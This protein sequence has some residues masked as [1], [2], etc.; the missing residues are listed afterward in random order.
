[1]KKL[2]VL[3]TDSGTGAFYQI[4]TGWMNALKYAGHNASIWDG[5]ITTWNN[6]KPDI[7]IGC[8]GWRQNFRKLAD[9][10]KTK[11]VI[12]A[13]PYCSQTIQHGGPKINESD[14]AIG[15][16]IKQRPN[17]AFGYGLQDDIDNY[18][19][20]WNSH[21]INVMPMPNAADVIKY[22]PV[23]SDKLFECNIGWLGGYWPYKAI[24][25][26]NYILKAMDMFGG[27]WYG[28]SGPKKFWKGKLQEDKVNTFFC[29]AKVCPTV[30]EPHTSKYGIDMPER[31]FKLAVCG[32]L[33]ISDPVIGINR[34]FSPES[35]IMA[36]DQNS[37][38]LQCKKY[39]DMNK[40]DR[41]NKA[42][43]LRN[44]V[45]KNHTYFHR[46]EVLLRNLGYIDESNECKNIIGKLK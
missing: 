27:S 10:T 13:N 20:K 28:W 7:Y 11:V 6:A 34:F 23:P 41:M 5:N 4:M 31:I 37:Y 35:L 29:S 30:V 36:K 3:I 16:V 33:V 24:N 1:M 2:N 39:I 22:K 18:W 45:L 12:H 32:S 19:Y 43:K 9:K 46:I 8:S 21:N 14:D 17:F 26:D 40:N 38:I 44:E 25:L 15:W 42:N